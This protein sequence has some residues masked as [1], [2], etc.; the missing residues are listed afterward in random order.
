MGFEKL[1]VVAWILADVQPVL[2]QIRMRMESRKLQRPNGHNLEHNWAVIEVLQ[3]EQLT[4]SLIKEIYRS[5]R[6]DFDVTRAK[7]L[8][9]QDQ[10]L[11]NLVR[12]LGGVPGEGK[13]GAKKTFWERVRQEWNREVGEE[14]Y[15]QRRALEMKYKRL[16]QKLGVAQL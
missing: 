4:P 2:S 9:G 14:Q 12:R 3:P 15:P 16:K 6:K 1:D 10:R 11:F 7:A 13:K 5:V 8:T